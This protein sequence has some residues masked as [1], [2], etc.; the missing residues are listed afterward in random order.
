MRPT[1]HALAASAAISIYAAMGAAAIAQPAT[2]GA[3]VS[4]PAPSHA[5]PH[6]PSQAERADR[7]R[8]ILQLKP[9]QEAALQAYVGASDTAHRGMMGGMQSPATPR[10]TPERLAQMQQLMT[11][12]QSAM[13]AMIDAT[14][15]FYDQLDAD[16][17][18]AFDALP[19]MVMHGGMG[20]MGG[21]MRMNTMRGGMDQ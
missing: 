7:L 2:S 10:T 21:G 16:Q 6:A 9:A 18:R 3:A 19:T 15:R 8:A 12:H 13:T 11:Q 1:V 14:R 17:K 4:P 5:M 20:P